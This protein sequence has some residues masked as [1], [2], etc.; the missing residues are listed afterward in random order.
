MRRRYTVGIHEQVVQLREDGVSYRAIAKMFNLAHS[1]V[2]AGATCGVPD[3][4]RGLTDRARLLS[5]ELLDF[6]GVALGGQSR[7]PD[8]MLAALSPQQRLAL[9]D[10]C[11]RVIVWVECSQPVNPTG[12]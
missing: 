7:T 5:H 9:E 4:R 6:L 11:E 8:Q 3:G 12:R 10:F 2:V 1:T